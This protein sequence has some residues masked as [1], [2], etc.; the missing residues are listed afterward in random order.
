MLAIEVPNVA[1][2]TLYCRPLQVLESVQD[3]DVVDLVANLTYRG[4]KISVPRVA[5]FLQVMNDFVCHLTVRNFVS[6]T[7]LTHAT[8]LADTTEDMGWASNR[9]WDRAGKH[10]LH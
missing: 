9:L 1:H 6:L 5:E 4:S 3:L 10:T 2:Y 8:C 7:Y